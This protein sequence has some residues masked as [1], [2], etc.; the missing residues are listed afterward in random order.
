MET[1]GPAVSSSPQKKTAAAGDSRPAPPEP[2]AASATSWITTTSLYTIMAWLTLPALAL[3]AAIN[4]QWLLNP[5]TV[6]VRAQDIPAQ[7]QVVNQASWNGTH[8]F[9]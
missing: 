6:A 4:L 1:M 2:P 7:A 8:I 5:K 3:V 9:S